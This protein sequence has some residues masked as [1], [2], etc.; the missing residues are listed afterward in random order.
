MKPQD[1]KQF[2][3]N[4]QTVL[5]QN[6]DKAECA[7]LEIPKI[8]E[9]YERLE[10]IE[11]LLQS[12]IKTQRKNKKQKQKITSIQ[13]ETRRISTDIQD[14]PSS[15]ISQEITDQFSRL[16]SNIFEY[17]EVFF[18]LRF[19]IIYVFFVNNYYNY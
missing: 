5:E 4:F 13:G 19:I 2:L 17:L 7:K 1:F 18:K 9:F 3:G 11:G 6:L 15:S 8:R 12:S 14:V 16:I 10:Q